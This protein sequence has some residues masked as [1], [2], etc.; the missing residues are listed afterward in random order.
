[1]FQKQWILPYLTVLVIAVTVLS[2][3]FSVSEASSF[4]LQNKLPKKKK[5]LVSTPS[6][7]PE[8][9]QTPNPVITFLRTL[10]VGKG[11]ITSIAFSP[12]SQLFAAGTNE[13]IIYLWKINDGQLVNTFEGHNKEISAL[14]FNPIN[15]I[16]A[17]GSDDRTIRLWNTEN[18]AL[19][20]TVKGNPSTILCLAFSPDGQAL[21]ASYISEGVQIWRTSDWELFQNLDKES[22]SQTVKFNSDGAVLAT[23]STGINLWKVKDGS[24]L[25]TIHF[26]K[27]SINWDGFPLSQDWKTLAT[28]DDAGPCIKLFQ[29]GKTHPFQTF[30]TLPQKVFYRLLDTD[31][32]FS[33]NGKFLVSAS[34][35]QLFDY[36]AG[37]IE[38]E[39]T[40]LPSMLNLWRITDGKLLFTLR[41]TDTLNPTMVAFSPDSQIF[42]AVNQFKQIR[43]WRVK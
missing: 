32:A 35:G 3:I 23:V 8:S 37:T 36:Y 7:V 33:P 24:K 6:K 42:A 27:S 12:D 38:D 18:G 40:G 26:Q 31:F 2:S 1:M 43:V 11:W 15:K 17:S 5:P 22:R 13:G 4:K 39:F 41:E 25:Q 10:V 29:I 30:K 9:D 21:A 16:V 28:V 19:L 20:R 14:A 34:W